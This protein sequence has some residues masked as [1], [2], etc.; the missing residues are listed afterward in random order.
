MNWDDLRIF[1]AV[2]RT[3]RLYKAGQKLRLDHAT[4]ARRVASLEKALGAKLIDRSPAGVSLTEDG[5][6]LLVHAERVEAELQYVSEILGGHVERL[7]GPVR[8]AAPESFGALLLASNLEAFRVRYPDIR[9]ELLSSAQ[10]VSLSKR[11]ADIVISPRRPERGRV[12]VK[13]LVEL[14]MGLYASE[15]YISRRGRP[16]TLDDLRSHDFVTH[17][18]HEAAPSGPNVAEQVIADAHIVF[19]GPSDAQLTAVTMGLGI[20]LLHHFAGRRDG[21]LVRLL[22]QI[23]VD[24]EYWALLHADHRR[25]PRVRAVL[26]FVDDLLQANREFLMA[27][28]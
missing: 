10:A 6:S 21:R 7:S 15:S 1:I 3:G 4:I 13:K 26:G 28:E 9:I 8:V 11:E 17:I 18:D 24:R 22:P 19:S 16:K 25:T 27:A 12:F 20:G 5:A 14:Q 2:A 23:H